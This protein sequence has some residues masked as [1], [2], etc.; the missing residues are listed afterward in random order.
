MLIELEPAE[1][2]SM[3]VK[4]DLATECYPG[5]YE[6]GGGEIS[7]SFPTHSFIHLLYDHHSS[8]SIL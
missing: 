3:N 7:R 1:I 6:E 4:V 5:L 2:H 8:K